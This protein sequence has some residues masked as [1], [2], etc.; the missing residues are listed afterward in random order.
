MIEAISETARVCLAA[1]DEATRRA[2]TLPALRVALSQQGEEG[3]Q[4]R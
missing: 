2:A 3:R 1:A 4:C